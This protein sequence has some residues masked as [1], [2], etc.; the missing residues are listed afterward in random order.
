VTGIF[1]PPRDA[2]ALAEALSTYIR[3]EGLR[4]QHG[5]AGRKRALAQFDPLSVWTALHDH[6][7]ALMQARA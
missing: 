5:T 1:V 4:R 3:N 2:S 7:R 6:Y